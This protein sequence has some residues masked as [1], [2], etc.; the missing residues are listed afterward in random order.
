MKKCFPFKK[1]YRITVL[2]RFEGMSGD[3]VV[4]TPLSNQY[5]HFKMDIWHVFKSD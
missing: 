5:V 1:C 4:Q 3:C 2:L